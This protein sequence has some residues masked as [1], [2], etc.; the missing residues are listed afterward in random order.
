MDA[1]IMSVVR[2]YEQGLPI[3]RIS[4]QLKISEQKTRKILISAGAWSNDFSR[5]IAILKGEGKSFEEIQEIV[6]LSRNTVLS[7]LP[8]DRGM[9]NAEFPTL[10][11]IRI[12]ESRERQKNHIILRRRKN[13]N[14]G[15]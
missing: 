14:A 12:R 1:L 10:N 13:K 3:A 7:Y 15:I 4:K 8:Y 2:L 9:K 5:K 11:A 6:G